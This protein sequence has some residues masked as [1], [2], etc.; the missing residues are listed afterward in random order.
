M[1]DKLSASISDKLKALGVMKGAQDL[2]ITPRS[3][4]H[5]IEKVLKGDNKK[6]PQGDFFLV[7]D[8]YSQDHSQSGVETK[9]NAPLEQLSKWAKDARI[10][11]L[12]PEE[13][14]F[15][16]T[17]TTGLSG[18]T[19]TYAFLIGV[20]RFEEGQFHLAQFFMRNPSEEPAQLFALEDFLAPCKAIVSYNGKAFDLPLLLTRYLSHGWYPPFQE[21]SHIDLLHLARRLWRDRLASRTLGNLEAQILGTTREDEDVPG[22]MIPSLYFDYLRDGDARP[23][24]SV[25]YHNAMDVVS[26]SSL[27]NHMAALLSFPIQLGSQYCVDLISLARLFEDMHDLD[28]ATQLYLHG[29]EHDDI[30][31][32]RL[33]IQIYLGAIQRLAL[34]YKRQE[35]LQE[36]IRLWSIAAEYNHLEAHI[37]LAKCYEHRYKDYSEAVRWTERAIKIIAEPS[38]EGNAT[39][40]LTSHQ[41]NSYLSDL[42]HRLL[43]LYQKLSRTI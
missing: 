22:W 40:F 33:P 29:L 41:N 35:R 12:S 23:L 34:I 3:N 25:F 18:G 16:D 28:T 42:E 5:T 8:F 32:E 21:I 1:P 38:V 30:K 7:E 39:N 31:Q 6:T 11:H 27:L 10:E 24:K 36:A 2:S 4:I 37:E 14:A 20:G 26:M 9:L 15:I 19:G 43:R 17:E 13:I